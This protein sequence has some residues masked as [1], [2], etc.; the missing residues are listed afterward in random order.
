MDDGLDSGGDFF[1]LG[2]GWAGQLPGSREL[3]AEEKAELRVHL[4]PVLR[5]LRS[6]AAILPDVLEQTSEDLDN[7][8]SARIGSSDHARGIRV[9]LYSDSG[10]RLA[11]LADQVQEWE[12]ES[13]AA[14]RRPAVWP[15]C[16]RHPNSHPLSAQVRDDAAVWLC[17]KT[18][19]LI[20]PIGALGGPGAASGK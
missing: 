19:D 1:D 8:I 14:A 11:G 13:L 7:V 10:Q 18:G 2:A 16:P 20:A 15:E 9:P 6:A 4:E 12:I 17:P 5:D 3:T